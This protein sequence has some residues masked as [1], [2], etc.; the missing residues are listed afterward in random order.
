MKMFLLTVHQCFLIKQEVIVSTLLLLTCFYSVYLVHYKE[1]GKKTANHV[2][3][4][5]TDSHNIGS[6]SN[7]VYCYSQS[8][9]ILPLH[10]IN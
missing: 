10:T 5:T 8:I 4:S 1:R 6:F 9:Q 7:W 3:Y 2:S